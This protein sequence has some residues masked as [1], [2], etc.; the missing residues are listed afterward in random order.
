MT[1][2]ELIGLVVLLFVALALPAL[3]QSV[4]NWTEDKPE[5]DA[6]AESLTESTVTGISDPG[7]AELNPQQHPTERNSG[8]ASIAQPRRHVAACRLQRRRLG[9]R[10]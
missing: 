7:V 1:A 6:D 3:G 2:F 9:G 5:R 10:G 8:R 4:R